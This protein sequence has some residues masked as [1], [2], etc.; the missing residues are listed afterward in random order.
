MLNN[1]IF[2]CLY[3]FHISSDYTA[4]RRL[5]MTTSTTTTTTTAPTTADPRLRWQVE[6]QRYP[7]IVGRNDPNTDYDVVRRVSTMINPR[8]QIY[9]STSMIT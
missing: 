9:S 1:H 5:M 6:D 7:P 2:V 4:Y 3:Q 8:N